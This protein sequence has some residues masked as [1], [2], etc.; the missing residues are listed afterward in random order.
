MYIIAYAPG[1]EG[2]GG[3]EGGERAIWPER[4]DEADFVVFTCALTQKNRHML[5]ALV[6]RMTKPGVRVVN[7]ARGP[8]IDATALIAALQS[9]HVAA[10]GLDVFEYEPLPAD[11]PLREMPECI[12]GS[13]NG[14][15][16]K[17]AVRRA[18]R[19]ALEKMFG[20]LACAYE[21]EVCHR[22]RRGRRHW[23]RF[24]ARVLSSRVCR[25][26]H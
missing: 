16:T 8:L 19:E 13:H 5:D 17:D 26:S 21:E 10:A 4:I 3:I 7:V 18:S 14:S 15:N 2:D 11:S 12:F 9:G 6:L 20:F 22:H 24:S 25:Y 1:V 23:A